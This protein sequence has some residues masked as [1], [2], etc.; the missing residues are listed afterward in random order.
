MALGDLTF[1]PVETSFIGGGGGGRGGVCGGS[2]SDG[3]AGGDH[4]LAVV[5]GE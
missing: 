4:S 2:G 1:L 3:D 5:D